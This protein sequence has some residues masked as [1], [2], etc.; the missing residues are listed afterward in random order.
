[1]K[2]NLSQSRPLVVGL[3]KS[4]VAAAL[5]LAKRGAAVT[6]TDVRTETELGDVA[7]A[8][9]VAGVRLHCGGH[10]EAD[11]VEADFI[12][13]SPGV[14]PL[15]QIAAARA[16]GVPVYSEI[17][18]ASW[19]VTAP[20]VAITGT[21]GK[22]T[23]TTL[24]GE[25]CKAAGLATFVGGNLGTPLVEVME[26]EAATS[27]VVVVEVSSFQLENIDTFRPKVAVL[28]NVT[29]DHLDRYESFA[30]YAAAKG[31]VFINQKESDV[32]IVPFGDE[33]SLSLAR[34]SDANVLTF[35][36]PTANANLEEATLRNKT[37]SLALSRADLGIVGDHNVQ[38][39]LASMLAAGALGLAANAIVST[40]KTFTGLPHRMVMTRELAAVRY[41]DDSKATNVGAAMAALRGLDSR[42]VLIAGGRDKGGSYAPL[43]ELASERCRAVIVLG[44]AAGLIAQA[45]SAAKVRT[46]HAA[47]MGDA[48]LQAAAIAQAGD[49]VLLAP[50]CSSFDM[51]RS[52]A[53]RGDEFQRCVAALGTTERSPA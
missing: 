3:G 28:L 22:S 33:L 11:F 19:F 43:A 47:S 50:A 14:P 16:K 36:A 41:Y 23:V 1:M 20:I 2:H 15:V 48:V 40:L 35:G 5:V 37:H 49:S 38:N 44:E 51:F 26:T 18:L 4:G 8:L 31:R 7:R 42:V 21:N 9:A 13:V 27:G 10:T 53:H 29:D 45:M 12:V 30:G 52:Y 34:V 32:A 39:A 17:E 6:A 24:I 46:V 25:M